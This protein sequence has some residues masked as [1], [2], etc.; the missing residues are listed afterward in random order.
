MNEENQ[1]LLTHELVVVQ[2]FKK[3]TNRFREIYGIYLTLIE[4]TE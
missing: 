3:I 4:K 1:M 2:D